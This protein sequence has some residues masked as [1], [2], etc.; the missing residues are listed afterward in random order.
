MEDNKTPVLG[1]ALYLEMTA[2]GGSV[3]QLLITPDVVTSDGNYTP[4]TVYRRRVTATKSRTV[5]KAFPAFYKLDRS[6]EGKILPQTSAVIARSD[7]DVRL[8]Y[9]HTLFSQIVDHKY[10][11]RLKPI[12]VEVGAVDLDELAAGKTPYKILSRITKSRKALGFPDSLI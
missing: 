7:A 12:V 3:L 1:K 6:A 9:A 11:L 4:M 8:K 10:K 5:W 2:P